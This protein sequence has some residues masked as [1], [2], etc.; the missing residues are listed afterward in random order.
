MKTDD[1]LRDYAAAPEFE[2]TSTAKLM[3]R[4]ADEIVGLRDENAKLREQVAQLVAE[5]HAIE[6][7]HASI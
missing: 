2:G 6:Q 5:K 1:Q 3:I 4:A 7:R